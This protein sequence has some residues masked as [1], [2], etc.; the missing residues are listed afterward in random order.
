MGEVYEKSERITLFIIISVFL[1]AF[2]GYY[3]FEYFLMDGLY[4]EK[5][6]NAE[7][8][9]ELDYLAVHTKSIDFVDEAYYNSLYI[10]KDLRYTYELNEET[11]KVNIIGNESFEKIIDGKIN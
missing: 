1:L 11:I 2:I 10:T 9:W 7:K 8:T 5:M 6:K 4:V 3:G